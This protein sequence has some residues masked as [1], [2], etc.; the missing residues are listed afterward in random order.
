MN[1]IACNLHT[2]FWQQV[3]K[4]YLMSTYDLLVFRFFLVIWISFDIGIKMEIQMIIY[5]FISFDYPYARLDYPV[6][7]VILWETNS[8]LHSPKMSESIIGTGQTQVCY[9]AA[10]KK[11][12]SY[13]GMAAIER[14][15]RWLSAS[16]S[17]SIADCCFALSQWYR[18]CETGGKVQ[19]PILLLTYDNK[20]INVWFKLWKLQLLLKTLTDLVWRSIETMSWCISNARHSIGITWL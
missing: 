4:L 12:G 16:C 5:L 20:A 10:W 6:V 9:F 19:F 3:C 15:Y 1:K 13:I 14:S 2:L 7:M 18:M 8:P 17:N 11:F